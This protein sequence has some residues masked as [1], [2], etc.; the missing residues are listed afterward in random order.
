MRKEIFDEHFKD[1]IGL[2]YWVGL[3][4]K[5]LSDRFLEKEQRLSEI[6]NRMRKLGVTESNRP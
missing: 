6:E 5:A 4:L 2:G 1:D 3:F